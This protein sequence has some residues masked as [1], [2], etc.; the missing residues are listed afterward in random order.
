MSSISNNIFQLKEV[1][2]PK[3]SNES[4]GVYS[5]ISPDGNTLVILDRENQWIY[6]YG[7]ETLFSNDS[8]FILL[9]QFPKSDFKHQYILSDITFS[10][11][12]TECFIG[13]Q[14][15]DYVNYDFDIARKNFL[16]SVMVFNKNTIEMPLPLENTIVY[17][18]VQVWNFI[19]NLP[20]IQ[21][22]G[23][24]K[25]HWTSDE[26][27]CF[28]VDGSFNV[29]PMKKIY[30]Q[31]IN[32]INEY[33]I[34][35]EGDNLLI[36]KPRPF[37]NLEMVKKIEFANYIENQQNKCVL[38]YLHYTNKKLYKVN[39]NQITTF[40]L[41]DLQLVSDDILNFDC[42]NGH[43]LIYQ[44][45][46]RINIYRV[47][48]MELQS[49]F[50]KPELNDPFAEVILG[51]RNNFAYISNTDYELKIFN[52]QNFYTYKTSSGRFGSGCFDEYNLSFIIGLPNK[53]QVATFIKLNG[54][55]SSFQTI[56][57][58]GFANQ[59]DVDSQE[60]SLVITNKNDHNTEIYEKISS[61]FSDLTQKTIEFRKDVSSNA[62]EY[63]SQYISVGY[64]NILAKQ[65]PT[66]PNPSYLTYFNED[67]PFYL[68]KDGNTLFLIYKEILQGA[69][70]F[71]FYGMDGS[72]TN[73]V[74]SKFYF[75]T[76]PVVGSGI[77]YITGDRRGDFIFILFENNELH[78]YK[79]VHLNNT[80][81]IYVLLN[82]NVGN[83]C[84][85]LNESYPN[86]EPIYKIFSNDRASL[87]IVEQL[88]Q[89]CVLDFGQEPLV[90]VTL[91][92][93]PSYPERQLGDY[94]LITVINRYSLLTIPTLHILPGNSNRFLIWDD[95]KQEL[96]TLFEN[97]ICIYGPDNHFKM[98]YIQ[99][100][101]SIISD[102]SSVNY[103][104]LKIHPQAN[105][106]T[107]SSNNYLKFYWMDKFEQKL[108]PIDTLQR[109]WIKGVEKFYDI[110]ENN[111][112]YFA[113]PNQLEIYEYQIK[114]D[115]SG[116]V[117]ASYSL[118]QNKTNLNPENKTL[119][120]V[121][122]DIRNRIRFLYSPGLSTG[123]MI[124]F[125]CSGNNTSL[126]HFKH[127]YTFREQK[128]DLDLVFKNEDFYNNV[129][130]IQPTNY[131]YTPKTT[132]GGKS[133]LFENTFQVFCPQIFTLPSGQGSFEFQIKK[134]LPIYY[135]EQLIVSNYFDPNSYSTLLSLLRY[136]NQINDNRSLDLFYVKKK[137]YIG[138]KANIP[139]TLKSE[140]RYKFSLILANGEKKTLIYTTPYTNENVWTSKGVRHGYLSGRLWTEFY[141]DDNLPLEPNGTN[142]GIFYVTEIDD[143]DQP[144]QIS[145]EIEGVLAGQELS[146]VL[147]P[148]DIKL[149]VLT[150][151][152]VNVQT[153]ETLTRG[154][155]N[156]E[157]K[158]SMIYGKYS[159]ISDS[160][161][162]FIVGSEMSTL[163]NIIPN[164]TDEREFRIWHEQ[165]FECEKFVRTIGF[166]SDE[167]IAWYNESDTQQEFDIDYN[168][169]ILQTN[170]SDKK[171][172]ENLLLFLD[173]QR[174]NLDT[175]NK[176]KSYID[177]IN[178]YYEKKIIDL[179]FE[180][181]GG[182]KCGQYFG[183][184]SRVIQW[185]LQDRVVMKS[186]PLN[187]LW[188]VGV[189]VALIAYLLITA[190]LTTPLMIIA[191]VALIATATNGTLNGDCIEQRAPWNYKDDPNLVFTQVDKGVF[192]TYV[193]LEETS[194]PLTRLNYKIFSLKNI[195]T[196]HE[197]FADKL[198][199]YF[200]YYMKIKF[201]EEYIQRYHY[202]IIKYG[203][204]YQ[205]VKDNER[206]RWSHT[207]TYKSNNNFKPLRSSLF[208][209]VN[210]FEKKDPLIV[211]D[212]IFLDYVN[213]GLILVKNRIL[214][215]FNFDKINGLIQ[216]DI[217]NSIL[218][219]EF[220]LSWTVEWRR[221]AKYKS[222]YTYIYG[223]RAF[224][225]NKS[226]QFNL[227]DYT[228]MSELNN[229][230][231]ETFK[232]SE[233][234]TFSDPS[235]NTVIYRPLF[236]ENYDYYT[237][238]QPQAQREP[239]S[240]FTDLYDPIFAY[241]KEYLQDQD[242]MMRTFIST[243]NNIIEAIDDFDNILY[244]NENDWIFRNF[245]ITYMDSVDQNRNFIPA[246]TRIEESISRADYYKI[247]PG[248]LKYIILE[249]NIL[250]DKSFS[251]FDLK[252]IKNYNFKDYG[253]V[254]NEGLIESGSKSD[255]M[256]TDTD[257]GQFWWANFT[258]K[259]QIKDHYL[260]FNIPNKLGKVLGN[261]G[262]Y[263]IDALNN[264][265]SSVI[266][267]YNDF[268]DFVVSERPIFGKYISK[269]KNDKKILIGEINKFE[270]YQFDSSNSKYKIVSALKINDKIGNLTLDDNYIYNCL[271][272]KNIIKR[273]SYL[274]RNNLSFDPSYNLNLE[275]ILNNGEI[276][277]Q[278]YQ[279][280]NYGKA[281]DIFQNKYYV[282]GTTEGK[283]IIQKMTDMN[284]NN[285][286]VIDCGSSNLKNFGSKIKAFNHIFINHP[287]KKKLYIVQ[288]IDYYE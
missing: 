139:S 251:F 267:I 135:Q 60:N 183:T 97:K 53:G 232:L 179:K 90:K 240:V 47:R 158:N 141:N 151:L 48:D 46:G 27:F 149:Y 265:S 262:E 134:N 275:Y 11:D 260:K 178:T 49:S 214:K 25:I 234:L 99:M 256:S 122:K 102:S 211:D 224:V 280:E 67:Y 114:L 3:L 30:R 144:I 88:N 105:I 57:Y 203:C 227:R 171:Y 29:I 112:F 106:L 82:K 68:P 64:R 18:Q 56:E 175:P 93:L 83:I 78:L 1:I 58:N 104:D 8:P 80:D 249:Q 62:F 246:G 177:N 79:R 216:K 228:S 247:Y 89:I 37:F 229:D 210:S 209:M 188:Y 286:T 204:M 87:L 153:E 167:S 218:N 100:S 72:G 107:Y 113:N 220:K 109:P 166:G 236:K 161:K 213:S 51:D 128:I 142:S 84:L 96:F 126:Q 54:I 130:R 14:F 59:F 255:V 239:F 283:V 15:C 117:D 254:F 34:N 127:F 65:I 13:M 244:L 169:N 287:D 10:S 43:I 21:E 115:I 288:P 19:S 129:I 50:Q 238:F 279:Y 271:P 270:I 74:P 119:L 182:I 230:I 118:I 245:Y 35:T 132:D 189:I 237:N 164:G 140:I 208:S 42:N 231:V 205:F 157:D 39:L 191:L 12:S 165:E 95:D 173:V 219:I 125:T 7:R 248:N 23:Y 242:M 28:G 77:K 44:S 261:N 156:R 168:V 269:T 70:R 184:F 159:S 233:S 215:D 86:I 284:S 73:I 45:N 69:N 110:I 121:N 252:K 152:T 9:N 38:F 197:C 101:T 4:F 103:L 235:N 108:I 22:N 263:K 195:E 32:Q 40:S 36:D 66:I 133:T 2:Q 81:E 5:K 257:S 94:K 146:S 212:G 176:V 258:I 278:N 71:H 111:H 198:K 52:G 6:F 281:F 116:N 138:L 31:N 273:Y 277:L 155:G 223:P 274:I 17:K 137:I 91:N 163:S 160:G 63:L 201:T 41:S 55:W 181:Y 154:G 192:D 33:M 20:C 185:K 174:L 222:E 190:G 193:K 253:R 76:E 143:L 221:R 26:L 92:E 187:T 136:I 241:S 250:F 200:F 264:Y 243:N 61:D 202:N 172:D 259:I 186:D 131:Y 199:V 162:Y 268:V 170:T 98:P 147:H 285:K 225:F 282:I 145:Y 196:A 276:I 16:A 266:P 75:W 194:E 124:Q 217:E 148:E 207:L 120:D 206:W 180:N 85:W 150:E 123:K 226:N 24:E 272:E